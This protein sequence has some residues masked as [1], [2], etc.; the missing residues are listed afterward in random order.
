MNEKLE[1]YRRM[2]LIRTVENGILSRYSEGKMRCPVHLSI[3]QEAAAVGV[4]MALPDEAQVYA[5]HRSHHPYLAKGG[6][7][8]ALVAELYGL[9]SGCTGGF[10]GSMYLRD[11]SVGFVGSYAVVGDCISVATGA[12]LASRLDAVSNSRTPIVAYFGDSA[13]ETGQFWESVN[14]AALHKLPILYVCENNG[15]ATSTPISQ[16]QP[17]TLIT[18]RVS[19]FMPVAVRH[20]R[21]IGP[22]WVTMNSIQTVVRLLLMDLPAFL[23]IKTYRYSAHVGMSSDTALGYRTAEEVSR[24]RCM[25]PLYLMESEFRVD[26]NEILSSIEDDNNEVVRLAFAK[27]E[28]EYESQVR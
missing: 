6:D 26:H 4:M 16:R 28:E 12:A 27:A 14:F 13:V 18:D 20:D 3:G 24:F 17:N 25:D 7:V 22:A 23:E 21:A 2:H 9:A 5:S 1:S 15:Y 19:G 10:G 8:D 11:E